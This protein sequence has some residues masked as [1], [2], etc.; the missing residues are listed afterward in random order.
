[1]LKVQPVKTL[2]FD[3]DGTLTDPR[4]GIVRC[5]RYA[6]EKLNVY[7]PPES[8]LLWCIGPPLKGSFQKLLIDNPECSADDALALYRERFKEVG[9]YE[10]TLYLGIPELLQQLINQKHAL[11]VATSKPVIFAEKI[12][13]H[14]DLTKYFTRIYGSELDGRLSDK[15]ELIGHI[16]KSENL[17]PESV[18]MIGDR[19]HDIIGA[20]KNG[21][22]SIGVTWGY[23]SIEELQG[24]NPSKI[25]TGPEQLFQFI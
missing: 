1:M 7:A 9:M 18:V 22:S 2:L 19:E 10:N 11:Y 5:I 3:L 14:F 16:I 23:G 13:K 4:D 17:S 8:D 15:G 24:I 21:I 6:L 25:A 12:M 20:K